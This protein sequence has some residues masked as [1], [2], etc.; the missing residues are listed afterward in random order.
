MEGN[1]LP[2]MTHLR[3]I[4]CVDIDE[5]GDTWSFKRASATTASMTIRS[6]TQVG[7]PQCQREVKKNQGGG[8][9]TAADSHAEITGCVL[10]RQAKGLAR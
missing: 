5:L 1:S 10:T 6:P 3:G 9:K 7:L 8:E 2:I 4:G